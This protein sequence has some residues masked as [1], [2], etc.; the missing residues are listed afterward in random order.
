VERVVVKRQRTD[1]SIAS[2]QASYVLEGKRNRYDIYLH[3]SKI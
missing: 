2:K 1:E 3:S